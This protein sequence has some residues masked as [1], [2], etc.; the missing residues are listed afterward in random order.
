MALTEP[1]YRTFDD[2]LDSVKIDLYTWDLEGLIAP[3]QLI[4]VAMRVNYDLGLRINQARSKAIEIH[5]GK[6]KL[7]QDFYVLN[8]GLVCEEHY[9]EEIPSYNK[10]YTEGILEGV[11]LAQNF[12]AD[13]FVNQSTTIVDVLIGANV[14]NHQLHTQN[15]IVQA[16]DSEGVALDFDVNIIDSENISLFS[17][18]LVTIPDVK[19]IIMG[20]KISTMGTGSGSCPALLDCTA[21]GTPRVHYVTNGRRT[22]SR[23]LIPLRMQKSVSVSADC[24][25]VNTRGRYDAYIKNGFMHT[26]FDEGVIFINYQSLMEDDDGNLLVLDH[27]Y[28]NEYY[29]YALKQRI[30]ENLF[31][32][33]ENVSNHMQL[34]DQKLRG[35]RANALSFV[36]TPDFAEMRKLHDMNR[37]AQY[38]N[39]YNMFKSYMY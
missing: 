10:T 34:M 21:D 25:N 38:H 33:G 17:T 1:Q 31:M 28:C 5:K 26:N 8:F 23:S 27:P 16:F 20:A 12:L 11:S 13:K 4:K 37:R 15:I 29:E 2:L 9:T 6:G 24:F 7:P 18:S 19:V 3:Q 36:N 22:D 39:Y 35:A 30:Y 14:I 32:S